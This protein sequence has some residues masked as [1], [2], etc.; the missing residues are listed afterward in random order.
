MS[1]PVACR[2]SPVACPCLL[3]RVL[4][5]LPGAAHLE[6]DIDS[7][8]SPPPGWH[9]RGGTPGVAPRCPARLCAGTRRRSYWRTR[10]LRL[11]VLPV[12]GVWR[13]ECGG[14]STS[15]VRPAPAPEPEPAPAASDSRRLKS[16]PQSQPS[17]SPSLRPSIPSKSRRGG[18][19]TQLAKFLVRPSHT[20][21][22]QGLTL[23]DSAPE[24]WQILNF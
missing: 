24:T 4:A 18:P 8:R 12:R 14:N 3:M 11:P 22:L 21:K 19:T 16:C 1:V 10:G 6:R 2:L 9:P 13:R 15:R 23:R 7:G 5:I 17:P 20:R